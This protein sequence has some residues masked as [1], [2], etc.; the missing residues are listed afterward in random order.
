MK[1]LSTSQ[2]YYNIKL[3]NTYN[4]YVVEC[5]LQTKLSINVRYSCADYGDDDFD[6]YIALKKLTTQDIGKE[7]Y[8][9]KVKYM[10][11]RFAFE[12]SEPSLISSSYKELSKTFGGS[13]GRI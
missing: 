13:E 3:V 1:F 7:S 4:E 6:T 2:N 9:G 5:L 12:E 10:F 11:F 8:F